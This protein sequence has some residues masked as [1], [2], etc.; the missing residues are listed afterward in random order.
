MRGYLPRHNWGTVVRC[1]G[2]TPRKSRLRGSV[3]RRTGW[4][5]GK[6]ATTGITR[7]SAATRT[8]RISRSTVS[9]SVAIAY[10]LCDSEPR[11]HE[12]DNNRAKRANP[13]QSYPFH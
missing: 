2:Y 12:A 3:P 9:Q 5:P 13:T 4:Q 1:Y 10:R 8:I 7:T 6:T 11:T